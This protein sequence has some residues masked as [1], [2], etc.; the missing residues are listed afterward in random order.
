MKIKSIDP[1]WLFVFTITGGRSECEH[2]YDED[3]E[4]DETP[5]A[6]TYNCLHC[7]AK[8]SYDVSDIGD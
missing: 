6:G 1:R 5:W 4:Y 2:E 3:L 8:M 7:G